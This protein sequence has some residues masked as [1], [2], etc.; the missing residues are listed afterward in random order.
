MSVRMC[1]PCPA[2]AIG[3][4][5]AT[6]ARPPVL[7][8]GNTSDATERIF[9]SWLEL[10]L[11][12]HRLSNEADAVL[13]AAEA[14]GVEF[15]VLADDEALR[16]DDAAIDDDVPEIGMTADHHIRQDDGAFEAGI[17]IGANAGEKQAAVQRGAGN[18]AIARNE[19]GGGGAAAIVVVVHEL[20][21]WLDLGEGPDRPG[22]VVD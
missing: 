5:P 7:M 10:Q 8:S 12:D 2:S 20:G 21:R 15:R 19:R 1:I 9:M 17:G 18:D 22:A 4:A 16:N 3:N 13:R 6:S 14:L 11:V